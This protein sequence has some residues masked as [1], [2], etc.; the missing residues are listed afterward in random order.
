MRELRPGLWRWTARHPDWTPEEGGPEGWDPEVASYLYE[1]P[2]TLVLFDPL[3]PAWDDLDERVER[4]GPPNVLVT[5]YWHVRSAPEILDRYAGTRVFGHEKAL[6]EMSKR[7]AATETFA[8]GDNLPGGVEAMTTRNREALFW[9][10][11]HAALVAG[12]VLLGRAGGGVRVCPDSWLSEKLTPEGLREELRAALLD[13]P[14]ELILLTHGEPVVENARA[15]LDE[16][17]VS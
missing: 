13:R 10:P 6:D 1:T 8:A 11:D 16:A 2:D 12:D 15:A 7:V 9:L 17:L 14:V 5:I 4:L 3:S